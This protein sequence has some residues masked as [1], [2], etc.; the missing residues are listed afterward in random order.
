M[1][2]TGALGV[3]I[4]QSLYVSIHQQTCDLYP[5]VGYHCCDGRRTTR[6]LFT[7]CNP[8]YHTWNVRAILYITPAIIAPTGKVVSNVY[9]MMIRFIFY[10]TILFSLLLIGSCCVTSSLDKHLHNNVGRG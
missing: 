3:V 7:S 10:A 4:L 1:G 9:V 5:E 2:S 6:L 8:G